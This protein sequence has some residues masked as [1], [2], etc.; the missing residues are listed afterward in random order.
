MI[1]VF[2]LVS[3]H[4]NADCEIIWRMQHLTSTDT[5]VM[6]TGSKRPS[7]LYM[8]WQ[9]WSLEKYRL[10]SRFD[11][12]RGQVCLLLQQLNFFLIIVFDRLLTYKFA[13]KGKPY[14]KLGWRRI[15]PTATALHRQMYT[16]LAE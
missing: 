16:A 12:L 4:S 14:P 1:L 7:L 6:P 15:I 13:A 11:D 3:W 10:K 8:P 5:L 9:R 2:F